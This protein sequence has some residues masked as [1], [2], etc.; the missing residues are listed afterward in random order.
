MSEKLPK[1]DR[2]REEIVAI[3]ERADRRA[4]NPETPKFLG[5][6]AALNA[7]VHRSIL[8]FND[9]LDATF[10][11]LDKKL[12]ATNQHLDA[13]IVEGLD[14]LLGNKKAEHRV[15]PSPR[16]VSRFDT[17]DHV[18][19]ID[20]DSLMNEPIGLRDQADTP[21]AAT[22]S[23]DQPPESFPWNEWGNDEYLGH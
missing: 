16:G 5:K 2:T 23:Q 7:R 17:A 1:R 15:A 14:K 18:G 22:A 11:R 8:G 3:I 10:D 6:L 20:I 4:N 21:D 13:R 19:G 9:R 12:D